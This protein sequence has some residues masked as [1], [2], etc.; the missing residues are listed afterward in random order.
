M[1]RESYNGDNK[2]I[3]WQEMWRDEFESALEHDPVVI[4]PVGSIEQHGP[5]CPMDVDIVGPFYM[6]VERSTSSEP[7]VG[8]QAGSW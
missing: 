8:C 1:F 3:L 7:R 6:A 4:L 5:H 2:K